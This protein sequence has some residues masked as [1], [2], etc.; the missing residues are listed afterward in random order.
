MDGQIFQ[1]KAKFTCNIVRVSESEQHF[2]E[3]LKY[4]GGYIHWISHP[5][6]TN[7]GS[8][9]RSFFRFITSVAS[10]YSSLAC[11]FLWK[12]SLNLFT[13]TGNPPAIQRIDVT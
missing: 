12:A 2:E 10:P 4:I 7:S 3:F 8:W 1:Q 5:V 11:V 13:S 9:N 6:I